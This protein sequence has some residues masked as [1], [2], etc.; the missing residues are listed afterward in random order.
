MIPALARFE[1]S[2]H[3]R[4]RALQC[5]VGI[6]ER[7]LEEM[8]QPEYH[9]PNEER[10]AS[11]K[12]NGTPGF[13]LAFLCLAQA[14]GEQRFEAAMHEQL[15]R[16]ARAQELLG[17]GVFNGISG[18][19][20]VAALATDVIEPRYARLVEQCDEVVATTLESWPKPPRTYSDYDLLFGCAGMR[21]AR[22]INGP[23]DEDELSAYLRWLV[24]DTAHWATRHQIRTDDPPEHNL[25]L[26]HGLPGILSAL[27][28]THDAIDASLAQ[29][30]RAQA[31]WLVEQAVERN[32]APTWPRVA[33]SP[34]QD[35]YR[36]VWCFGGTGIGVSLLQTA[37]ATQDDKLHTYA[38]D[39]LT[40]IARQRPSTWY[41]TQ[42]GICHGTIG[43]ALLFASAADQTGNALLRDTSEGLV[44]DTINGLQANVGKCITRGYDTQYYDAIG[45]LVG[46][47]GVASGLVT[48]AG[49]CSPNWL[50]LHGIA[51]ITHAPA[52]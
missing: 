32:G 34:Q 41:M 12:L 3:V 8:T 20:A 44:L 10:Y 13:A 27:V 49:A 7:L 6:G 1:L 43:N 28:L 21:M 50:R 37:R 22:C 19:R 39:L 40:C 36:A 38:L 35:Y 48:L 14:T 45:H 33:E 24:A 51:P 4:D 11:P 17:L 42:F 25:G 31:W 26:A 29:Q 15:R 9:D 46:V 23:R 18:L 52:C 47:A 5:A 2:P 16:A 30:M